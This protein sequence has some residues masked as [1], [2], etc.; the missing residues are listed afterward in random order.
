M[1]AE[2]PLK[3]SQAE[4]IEDWYARG[5]KRVSIAENKA[6]RDRMSP[7]FTQTNTDRIADQAS[8]RAAIVCAIKS[9]G[10]CTTAQI[11][12]YTNINNRSIQSTMPFLVR[13]GTILRTGVNSQIRFYRMPDADKK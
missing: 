5:M 3:R 10:R 2:R 12:D 13:D 4:Q 6:M 11:S 8:R 9:I 7:Y 1:V